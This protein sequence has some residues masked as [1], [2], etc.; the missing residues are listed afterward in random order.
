MYPDTFEFVF[1]HV[2][3][4]QKTLAQLPAEEI[5]RLMGSIVDIKAFLAKLD[6]K[7]LN[8]L[9]FKLPELKDADPTVTTTEMMSTDA[10]TVE[11]VI[12][13]ECQGFLFTEEELKKIRTVFP[14]VDELLSKLPK[15]KQ[16]TL[17]ALF[18]NM[19]KAILKLDSKDLQTL[20]EN[21]AEIADQL[22]NLIAESLVKIMADES[23]S[24][25]LRKILC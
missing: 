1:K 6:A 13:P 2:P 9:L 20:N 12:E 10:T 22:N 11:L 15:E 25:I 4:I 7:I 19:A 14:K 24:N 5:R 17:H 8:V 3:S 21:V 16:V 18:P 23:E